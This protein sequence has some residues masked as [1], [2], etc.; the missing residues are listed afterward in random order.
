[1]AAF[2]ELEPDSKKSFLRAYD[3]KAWR[4]SD[5]LAMMSRDI[6]SKDFRLSR[7]QSVLSDHEFTPD[8]SLSTSKT[9]ITPYD[10][11]KVDAAKKVTTRLRDVLK[12][13]LEKKKIESGMNN[14]NKTGQWKRFSPPKCLSH[15]KF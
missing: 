8:L 7:A 13:T 10:I 15:V 6:T 12:E 3:G 4:E 9:L 1:M 14:N 11:Q 5:T 2:I